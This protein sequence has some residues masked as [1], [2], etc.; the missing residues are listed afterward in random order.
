MP[1]LGRYTGA[2]LYNMV[3]GTP[4]FMAENELKLVEKVQTENVRFPT[5]VFMEP[6]LRYAARCVPPDAV[7]RVTS[8]RLA[9][10]A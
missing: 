2:T 1:V 9:R 4:P 6:H 3:V 5:D 10:H 8:Q 7:V